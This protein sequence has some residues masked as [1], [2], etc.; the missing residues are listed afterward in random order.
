MYAVSILGSGT[1]DNAHAVK[2]EQRLLQIQLEMQKIQAEQSELMDIIGPL[3]PAY[4]AE[5][6][7][8]LRSTPAGNH[9]IQ[10][11]GYQ[12]SD[13][14]VAMEPTEMV[15]SSSRIQNSTA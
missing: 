4:Y 11:S 1:D 12:L 3:S 8:G 6:I 10:Q 2:I 9:S 14:P 5:E 13:F 15:M 7:V